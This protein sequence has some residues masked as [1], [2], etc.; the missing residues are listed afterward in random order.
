MNFINRVSR[1]CPTTGDDGK[2]V[3]LSV[4]EAVERAA[5][6]MQ[7]DTLNNLV[8]ATR[9]VTGRP[10]LSKVA[11]LSAAKHSQKIVVKRTRSEVWFQHEDV[12]MR[13]LEQRNVR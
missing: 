3:D 10:L 9:H 7:A 12:V 13:N 1:Q 2:I 8:I 5:K 11:V 4:V 6:A